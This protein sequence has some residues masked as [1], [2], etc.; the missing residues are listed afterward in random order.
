MTEHKDNV[1]Y[2]IGDTT[3]YDY[4]LK[5]IGNHDIFMNYCLAIFENDSDEYYVLSAPYSDP[6]NGSVSLNGNI[7]DNVMVQIGTAD[8]D[9]VLSSCKESVS[10]ALQSFDGIP[11]FSLCFSCAGRKMIMWTKIFLECDIFKK[12]SLSVPFCGFYCYGEFSPI[13]KNIPF[14]FHGT[15]FV[16]LMIGEDYGA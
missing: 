1:L 13:Q 16:S 9:V 11:E 6:E 14:R 3:A 10:N 12:N 15:T 4:F 5:Y 8:K 2:K 7:P